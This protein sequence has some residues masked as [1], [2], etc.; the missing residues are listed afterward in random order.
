M[1]D[2][3]IV[4]AGA[5]G[6]V[7]ANRL[8]EDPDVKVLLLEAGGP[9]SDPLIQMPIGFGSLLKSE[10]DWDDLSE[11]EPQL[12][13][14]RIPVGHGRVLGGSSSINAMAYLRGNRADYDGWAA[15]GC[16]GW[17]YDDVLPYFK[18]SEDN[19]R[20]AN[21]YHA[22]GGPLGV[23]DSRAMTPCIDNVVA[24]F[25]AI[26]IDH[27]DDFNGA[28]QEGVGRTQSTTRDGRR[29]S[30]AT[31]FLHPVSDRPNLEVR[32][33]SQALR[34]LFEGRRAVGV[35]Y[36][37]FGEIAQVRAEREVI[38]SAGSFATPQLLMLSG[39]GPAEDLQLMLIDVLE[40][41]PVGRNLQDH[42]MSALTFFTEG[43]TL[44]SAFTP[45]NVALYEAEQRGPLASNVAEG[46][47]YAHTRSDLPAPDLQFS[48]APVMVHEDL[49][50][51]PFASAVSV[52]PTMV[53][54]ASRGRVTLRAARPKT[55][56]RIIHNYL[57][58]PEDRQT[59]I[60]GARMAMAI[61]EQAP[62]R[63][64]ST[65]PH[66]VPAS[67]SEADVMAFLRRT[68]L[69]VWHP[70][71]TCSMGAVVDD[72]LRVKGLEGLRVVDASV[73]PT[74]PRGNTNAPTTMVAE[75]GADLIK[76]LTRIDDGVAVAG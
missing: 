35:E 48:V 19:D 65:R 71:G 9:D 59:L 64:I 3:V 43:G 4:G 25:E 34:L 15:M 23:S 51:V 22:Q 11:Y 75:K 67:E 21:E 38:L 8:T 73:M 16:D 6:C 61:A 26:G 54:P 72:Q 33:W 63:E 12:N 7:L 55:K 1:Y 49:L 47:A 68:A 46:M 10:Y 37:R 69:T 50:G 44:E 74:V 2:Y 28:A 53:A 24:A 36:E 39:V 76:G 45:E 40:D 52:V 58:A 13:D 18:R 70:V 42:C 27:T 29:C 20:L 62:F 32:M 57:E 41:L 66:L 14:R 30:A 5:A 17:G 56:V 31:A 60:E